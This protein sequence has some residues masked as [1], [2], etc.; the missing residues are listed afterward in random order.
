MGIA[1]GG[2]VNIPISKVLSFRQELMF[3]QKG[4]QK[5]IQHNIAARLDGEEVHN[6]RLEIVET[7]NLN[8]LE[9]PLLARVNLTTDRITKPYIL[10]GLSLG[11]N[12]S[13]KA[14]YESEETEYIYGVK[15]LDEEDSGTYD[16]DDIRT[17]DLGLVTGI[18]VEENNL[19]FEL[20]YTY[21]L[22]D[23]KQGGDYDLKNSAISITAGYTF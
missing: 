14:K 6:Y 4:W 16:R 22:I 9:L 7:T 19:I 17:F 2:Y 8:Y 21:G 11:I 15:V 10:G 23:I 18:G 12:L 5:N 1:F 3:S 13:S 20:R